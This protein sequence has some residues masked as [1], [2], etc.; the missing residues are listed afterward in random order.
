MCLVT[1]LNIH[2]HHK[3][4]THKQHTYPCPKYTH[5]HTHT[6]YIY[7]ALALEAMLIR[8]RPFQLCPAPCFIHSPPLQEGHTVCHPP[9][10]LQFSH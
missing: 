9:P 6:I 5:I 7:R 1:Y 8:M 3:L 10:G 4:S 2:T